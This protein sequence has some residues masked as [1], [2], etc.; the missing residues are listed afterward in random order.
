MAPELLAFPNA[1]FYGGR[2]RAGPFAPLEGT[3][4]VHVV[5]EGREEAQ[6][7]SWANRAEAARAA[8]L[9]AGDP[10]AVLLT[11]YAGRTTTSRPAPERVHTIDSFQGREA[12]TVVLS[13]VLGS[14][15]SAWEDSGGWSS[16]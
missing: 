4:E 12:D 8:E 10:T 6:G 15:A 9:A 14:L 5:A 2:L 13:V 11:P 16:P 3:V 1:A 7:T